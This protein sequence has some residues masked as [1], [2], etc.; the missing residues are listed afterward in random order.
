MSNSSW[1]M[2]TESREMRL[3]RLFGNQQP[4]AWITGSASNRV[5][6][7]IAKYLFAHGYRVV[8]HARSSIMEGEIG[9]QELNR[10]RSDSAMLVVGDVGDEAFSKEAVERI[11]E[12][13]G[14]LDL[15]VNSAAIWDQ[16]GR[17]HV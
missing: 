16:I 15:L 2:L 5:G 7:H 6:R 10:L 14:R 4:V 3:D 1:N 9:V 13:Y 17:A 8:L 12:R 11:E